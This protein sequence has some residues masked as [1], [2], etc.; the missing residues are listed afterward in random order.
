MKILKL[1]RICFLFATSFVFVQN[2]AIACTC[3]FMPLSDESIRSAP[4][5]IVF[6]IMSAKI[7]NPNETN[8]LLDK[9]EAKIKVVD[10]IRGKKHTYRNIYFSTSSCCGSR[11]DVGRYYVAF[12]SETGPSFFANN[13]NIIDIGERYYPNSV[14]DIDVRAKISKILSKEEKFEN[15]FPRHVLDRVEQTPI[16]PPCNQRVKLK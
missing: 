12:I 4:N 14:G 15:I 5:I 8:L 9:V 10:R 6:R 2:E 16:L 11:L 3:S 7:V 1:F 13:G